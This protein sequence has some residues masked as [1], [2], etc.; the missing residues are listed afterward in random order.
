LPGHLHW[1]IVPRWNGDTNFMPI[2][3]GVSVI[4]QSLSA[5]YTFLRNDLAAA[6][7]Q[8]GQTA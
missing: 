7:S 5:L 6:E 8:G 1:H 4:P 3:G 2:V